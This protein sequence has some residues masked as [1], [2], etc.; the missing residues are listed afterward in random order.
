MNEVIYTMRFADGSTYVG[1]TRNFKARTAH[2]THQLQ[3]GRGVNDRV[4]KKFQEFGPPVFEVCALPLPGTSLRSLEERVI[5]AQEP[6]LNI[7]VQPVAASSSSG[8]VRWGPFDSLRDASLTLGLS[9]YKISYLAARMSYEDWLGHHMRPLPWEQD[10]KKR[11][12]SCGGRS[13]SVGDWARE[14]GV[15]PQVIHSRLNLGWTERQ[16]VGVDPA[17]SAAHRAAVAS[18][19][20]RLAARRE[21]L[22]VKFQGF[23]GTRSEAAAAFGVRYPT[24]CA[25]LNAG[26][27]VAQALG[28]EPRAA[29]RTLTNPT[30]LPARCRA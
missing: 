19:K 1:V 17:P 27:P 9:E 20:A 4:R 30:E 24:L 6:E 26:W 25:R 13:L 10:M 16:A 11:I 28:V 23:D 18:K 3:R 12:I 29:N 21:R 2:H 14:L 15:H 8:A 22:R 5:T 7:T